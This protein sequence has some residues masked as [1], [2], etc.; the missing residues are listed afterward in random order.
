MSN[1][2]DQSLP[3]SALLRAGSSLSE[4]LAGVVR[5]DFAMAVDVVLWKRALVYAKHHGVRPKSVFNAL[6]RLYDHKPNY[7]QL[8]NS[9]AAVRLLD[10]AE[11]RPDNVQA[12]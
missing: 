10:Q 9:F 5:E 1:A 3:A 6:R 7:R 8:I 12:Q 11:A 4:K 2:G